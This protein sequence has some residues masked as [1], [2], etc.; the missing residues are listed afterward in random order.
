MKFQLVKKKTIF[1]CQ[2]KLLVFKGFKRNIFVV[3]KETLKK[4]Q[5]IAVFLK[6]IFSRVLKDSLKPGGGMSIFVYSTNT[7][8]YVYLMQVKLIKN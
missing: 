5:F 2:S 1:N 8:K 3:L 6:T 7:R 4:K